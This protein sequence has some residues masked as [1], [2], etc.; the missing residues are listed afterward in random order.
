VTE[1]RDATVAIIGLG[2]MG[3]SLGRALEGRCARRIGADLDPARAARA[4]DLGV[5]DEPLDEQACAERADL[6][7]LAMPVRGIVD[8][9]SRLAPVARPGTV[10]TDLGSTKA[11]ICDAFDALP[12]D[13][14]AIGGHPMCGRERGGIDAADAALFQ[15]A[16]WVL[17]PTA[18]TTPDARTLVTQLAEA[19]GARALELERGV[20][21][22][23]VATASHLPYVVAQGLVGALADADAATDGAASALASTGFAGAT[24]LAAGDVEMWLDILLTNAPNVRLALADLRARLDELDAAFDDPLALASA[25]ERRS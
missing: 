9:A 16:T 6:L 19:V 12:A 24:R 2:L 11:A 13:I 7:V 1:L 18:R 3:G 22:R 4:C 15:G 23:A 21:D 10:V 14:A 5:I 17:C 25:L 8:A 20:H